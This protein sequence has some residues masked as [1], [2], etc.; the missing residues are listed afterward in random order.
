M[1]VHNYHAE[2]CRPVRCGRLRLTLE[3]EGKADVADQLVSEGAVLMAPSRPGPVTDWTAAYATLA[4]ADARSPLSPE[5]LEE[6]S[7]AAHLIGRDDEAIEIRER[8]YRAYL[9]EGRLVAGIRCGFWIG[10]TLYNRGE[11]TQAAGWHA[12]MARLADELEPSDPVRL[13]ARVPQA[14]AMWHGGDPA[15]AL[16]QFERAARLVSR[17]DEDMLVLIELGR[18]GCLA[19]LGR[20]D[21][22]LSGFEELM[23]RVTAGRVAPQVVGLAYCSAI[24]YCMTR[25]DLRRAGDWTKALT[26]WCD[27]QAGMVPYRGLC[28]VYRAEILQML[29]AWADALE[30]AE[31]ACARLTN[32]PN[33]G[34]AHYRLAELHRLRG[35]YEHAERS[36]AAATAAGRE[37]Q[38]GLA[39]LRHAQG[40][41]AAALAGLN[42]ALTETRS[43]SRRLPM[44]AAQARIAVD[45]GDVALAKSAA[46]EASKCA[47][48]VDAPYLAALAAHVDGIVLLAGGDPSAALQ[49]LRRAWT[50]WNQVDAPYEAARTRVEVSAACRA[51]GD[52]DA[53]QMEIDAA[54]TAFEQLGAAVDLAVLLR[55]KAAAPDHDLSPREFEVVKLLASGKSNRTIAA[56]LFL[57]E[58]T[59]ARHLSNIFG[60]LGVS[61][62]TAAAAYAYEHGL[63]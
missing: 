57:S 50:L 7:V 48:R 1:G 42:R 12:R 55:G 4:A 6:L 27:A 30:A 24:G 23:V 41:S 11:N 15:G 33:A 5:Q 16:P 35:E 10:F 63:T 20:S 46:D 59:V 43:A 45:I 62:R 36:Y 18:A 40:R 28:Q 53:A 44:V 25:Y 47:A 2:L 58:K 38:P 31:A 49:R 51:L 39:L 60:K 32:D 3:P 22:A 21:E 9:A 13:L 17:D 19:A 8:A 52:E 26:A 14:V 61:S 54:R 29:G 34:P 56:E 37:V